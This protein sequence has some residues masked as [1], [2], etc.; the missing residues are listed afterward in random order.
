MNETDFKDAAKAS[1]QA[2]ILGAIREMNANLVTNIGQLALSMDASSKTIHG[3]LRMVYLVPMAVVFFSVSTWLL[4]Q[5]K[6]TEYT[7][8][9]VFVCLAFPFFG[10]GI[11]TILDR[12]PLFG[13]TKTEAV[14]AAQ[15]AVLLA[16]G[17]T[18]IGT[19]IF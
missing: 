7:W 17:L 19:L 16:G 15:K 11:R 4:F 8:T 12:I 14:N 10:E 2:D 6:I 9:A 1:T 13:P 18:I 5:G 3:G